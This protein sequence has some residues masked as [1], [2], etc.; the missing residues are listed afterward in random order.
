MATNLWARF[1]RMVENSPTS[2]VTV[3]RINQDGSSIVRT[4][5]GGSMRVMGNNVPV[6]SKAFVRDRLIIGTAPDLPYYE[7]EA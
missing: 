6:D 1:Q 4:A 3:I 7:L 2:I 5:G